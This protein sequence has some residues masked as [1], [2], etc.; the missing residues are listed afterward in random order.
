MIDLKGKYVSK[1]VAEK[2]DFIL[3]YTAELS[4]DS[5]AASSWSVP[6]GILE[7]TPAPSASTRT[8]TIWLEGGTPDQ[9]YVVINAITTSG[10]RELVGILRVKVLANVEEPPE[11]TV[12]QLASLKAAYA[13]GALRVRYSDKEVEYRSLSEMKALI[14]EIDE[15]ISGATSANTKRFSLGSHHRG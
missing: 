1:K 7:A 6:S 3:D 2:L 9:E 15:S 5:I 11:Y 4:D 14:N 13:Q 12:G 10:G 8:A